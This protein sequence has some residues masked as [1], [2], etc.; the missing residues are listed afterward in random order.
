VIAAACTA[1]IGSSETLAQNLLTND[2]GFESGGFQIDA[3][4]P[5]QSGPGP[6]GWTYTLTNYNDPT[7][8]HGYSA[9]ITCPDHVNGN[10]SPGNIG[11]RMIAVNNAGIQ[12][13]AGS[14]PSVT[15]GT[16]YALSALL[17]PKG[18]NG[19]DS[20]TLGIDWY[21]ISGG[22]I[23][24]TIVVEMLPARSPS[25][26]LLP[27]M[28]TGA[29]PVGAATAAAAFSA[30]GDWKYADNFSLVLSTPPVPTWIA[31]GAGSWDS[32]SNWSTATVPYAVGAEADLLSSI[33]ANSTVYTAHNITLGKLVISNSNTYVIAGTGSMTLD[34]G[35][36]S[37]AEI[38]VA[39]GT[40]KINLPLSLARSAIFNV[41]I[42]AVLK[43]SD[44]LTL[45]PGISLT[46]TGGGAVIYESLIALGAGSTLN[47]SGVTVASAATLSASATM[48]LAPSTGTT[49]NVLELNSL[50]IAS[51]AKL[52]LGNNSLIV[53]N[54]NTAAIFASVA[55]GANGLSWDGSGICSSTAASDTR[56]LTALGCILN[57]D[58]SGSPIL[59][60]FAGQSVSSSDVLVR[61]TKY[62]DTNLDGRIDTSDYSRIDFG[63]LT[64]AT[65]WSNGDFNYDGVVNGSDYTLIDNAFNTQG[66]QLDAEVANPTAQIAGS[67]SSVPEPASFSMIFITTAMLLGRRR[68][69]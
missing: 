61:Y 17:G 55:S 57:S 23:S 65:G 32:P 11:T 15:P 20:A 1:S 50:S 63:Y 51:N 56:H 34:N 48:S 3:S 29:A 12:T 6:V 25:D 33:S 35:P 58:S 16:S 45:A 18:G 42:G 10:E 7:F 43:I 28:V 68:R 14:R 26:P 9:V 2:P 59:G 21:N 60:H 41:S 40:Q 53:H 62:G 37:P 46:S 30:V 5:N 31:P 22:F 66:A 4:N 69:V 27:Y 52:D 13:D 19:A 36:S 67:T 39:A 38:D 47:A 49:G 44:P 64:R 24:A 8:S 54:G